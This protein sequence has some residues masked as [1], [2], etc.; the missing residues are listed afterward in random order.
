LIDCT[1]GD[2]CSAITRKLHAGKGLKGFFM[3]EQDPLSCPAIDASGFTLDDGLVTLPATPGLGLQVINE[4]LPEFASVHFD[5]K[6]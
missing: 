3:A 4:R 1:I 2:H 6:A 5:M